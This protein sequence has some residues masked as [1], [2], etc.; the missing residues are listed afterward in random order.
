[1]SKTTKAIALENQ[2]ALARLEELVKL[3]VR[4]EPATVTGLTGE[5]RKTPKR[6]E[7]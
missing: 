5:R 2:E 1:V 7:G 6:G 4:R 3:L